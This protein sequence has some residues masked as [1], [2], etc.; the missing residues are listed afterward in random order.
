[1]QESSPIRKEIDKILNEKDKDVTYRYNLEIRVKE[2]FEGEFILTDR[3]KKYMSEKEL[4]EKIF[5][6]MQV[7][8]IDFVNDYEQSVMQEIWA[9]VILPSGTWVKC[10]Y[11]ARDYCEIILTRK[12]V[13]TENFEDKE[14]AEEEEFIFDALFHI[15]EGNSL[16]GVD[17]TN[18]TKTDLDIH[19]LPVAVNIELLNKGVEKVRKI[20]VGAPYRNVK[21]EDFIKNS[22]AH[23]TKDIEVDGEPAVKKI[24][25]V[26]AHNENKRDHIL[27]PQGIHL[28]DLPKYVQDFCGG[29]YNSNINCYMADDEIYVYPIYQTDRFEDEEKN[30]TVYRVPPALFPQFEKTYREDGKALYVLGLSD[31]LSIDNSIA[32]KL[33]DGNGIRYADSRKFLNKFVETKDNKAIAKRKEVNSEFKAEDLKDKDVVTLSTSRI[34]SNPFRERSKLAMRNGGVYTFQWPN[35]K[36]ELLYPGMP[37]RIFYEENQEVKEMRGVLLKEH[38][39]IA[40]IGDSIANDRHGNTTTLTLFALPFEEEWWVMLFQKPKKLV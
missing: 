25:V 15:D 27:I 35:S 37:A 24:S 29:V 9:R 34:N 33:A 4:N 7:T 12:P 22:L 14:D 8:N 30:L 20:T 17:Y 26:K 18:I 36:P 2:E 39:S 40:M 11:P 13:K 31:A 38:T 1:M 6:P 32:K 21:P 28:L 23:F 19:V 3:D 16:T 5:T 10:L